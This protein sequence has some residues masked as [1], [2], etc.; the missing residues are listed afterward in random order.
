M[1][2]ADFETKMAKQARE[3]SQTLANANAAARSDADKLHRKLS[4]SMSEQ[5]RRFE[6]EKSNVGQTLDATREC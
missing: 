6:A 4:N 1:T 3:A 5:A 2:L